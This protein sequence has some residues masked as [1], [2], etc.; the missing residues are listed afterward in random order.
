MDKRKKILIFS[1][2]YQPFVGGAEVAIKEITDRNIDIDF[3]LITLRYDSSLPKKERI[4]NIN[5]YRIGFSKKN[6]TMSDLVKFPLY[7]NK[8][9]FPITAFLKAISLNRKSSYDGVWSMMSYM[10]FPALFFKFIYPDVRFLLT[11]QEGDS[12]SHIT[13]RW[14]IKTVSP[15]YKLIFKKVDLI[16]VISHSLKDFARNMGY[17][18]LVEIV[19]NAV[20]IKHFLKEI[21]K[22]K[23]ENL[24]NKLD[25]K[26]GDIFI[27]TTSRLVEK[28]AVDDVIK[29]LDFLPNN[30]KFLILGIGPDLEKLKSL[31]KK[32]GLE[33]RVMFEGFVDYK[34]IPEYLSISDI[35]I[36]P[37]LSEGFGNSFIEAMAF[38]IPVIATPVGGIVDFLF[39]PEENLDKDPTGRFCMVRDPKS[40]A[41]VVKKIVDN[42]EKTKEIIENAK[43]LAIEKYDW[44]LITKDM[45]ENVFNKIL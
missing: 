32:E 11:L 41:T 44:D 29:S 24:M 9:L 25:K 37:S 7:L 27:I 6:P 26:D 43:K 20:D 10:G 14:R 19:P 42:P 1:L 8:V 33:R 40:I 39:D 16:Q 35:F 36:R 12:I 31:V 2:A 18:G 23:K 4:G 15:L 34:S 3:D 28:N 38:G 17:G 30:F 45:R 5:V 21:P 22:E 13:K